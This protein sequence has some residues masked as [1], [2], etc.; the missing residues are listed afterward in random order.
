VRRAKDT[1]RNDGST[2]QERVADAALVGVAQNERVATA[3]RRRDR[4]RRSLAAYFLERE[5]VG[6]V[7]TQKARRSDRCARGSL[8]SNKSSTLNVASTS[9]I[10]YTLTRTMALP[11][12]S[13]LRALVARYARILAR[14]VRRSRAPSSSRPTGEHFPDHFARDQKSGRTAHHTRRVVHAARRGRPAVVRAGRGRN[15][16]RPLQQ[17]LLE[18]GSVAYRRRPAA[19]ATVTAW[20]SR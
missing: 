9:G 12:E 19:T 5:H 8:A 14:M 18:T 15:G 10:G 20:R 2:R 17:R 7:G 11:S 16:R 4:G 1:R 6:R 3:E 13:V